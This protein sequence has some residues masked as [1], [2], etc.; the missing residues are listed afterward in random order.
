M[1]RDRR[2]TLALLADQGSEESRWTSTRLR[3]GVAALLDPHTVST[4]AQPWVGCRYE[5]SFYERLVNSGIG[6]TPYYTMAAV[7]QATGEIVGES[8]CAVSGGCRYTQ[9]VCVGA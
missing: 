7:L 4:L 1:P 8:P 6:H 9:D 3:V 2:Y 5:D